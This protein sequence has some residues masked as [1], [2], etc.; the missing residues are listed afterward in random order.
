MKK[1]IITALI[2]AAILIPAVVVPQLINVLDVI[3][4]VFVA[5]ATIE[6][7]NMY[8]KEKKIALPLK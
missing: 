2:M 7:L 8:D 6:L 3:F 5:G 1:R 4:M